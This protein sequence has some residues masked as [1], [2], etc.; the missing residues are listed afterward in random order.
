MLVDMYFEKMKN[1]LLDI[2]N[3]QRQNI[4]DSADTIADCLCSNGIWHLLDTGHMLMYEGVGRS[5]GMMAVR[6][7]RITVDV[8]NPSRQR[9]NPGKKNVYLDEIEGF[10]AFVLGKANVM[11]GDVLMIGSVSGKN[12]LPVEMALKAREMGVRTIALTS[13]AYSSS[14]KSE[15]PSGK[16]LFEVCDHVLDNCGITGDAL[17]DVEPIGKKI[18]PSSGIA[19]SY[20]M[21]ALQA[22]V[23]EK[24]I[25]LGKEPS[26]YVSNHIE[27]ASRLNNSSWARYERQGY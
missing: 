7:V 25:S 24:L 13:V 2:E 6:P 17:V 18:C 23:V 22:M 20:I 26:I 8:Q 12:I 27:N 11:A 4:S 15:H 16:R 9:P 5:G 21:W 10:P 14:L 1:I 3:T 19:A